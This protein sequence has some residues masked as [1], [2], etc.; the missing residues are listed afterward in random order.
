M[1]RG[2]LAL[3]VLV[4]ACGSPQEAGDT[5][6]TEAEEST[7]TSSP[8]TSSEATTT[9]AAP[10]TTTEGST[11][12]T[13]ATT[14]TTRVLAGNW[15]DQP[16]IVAD[17]GALG[18]WNGSAWV[19]AE[20]VGALPVVGDEDYQV[21][22]LGQ[23]SLTS[24]GPQTTV[25]EPLLNLGVQ[26]DEPDLLGQWP[27]PY[28]IAISGGWELHPHLFESFSDDGSYAGFAREL[29]AG[30]GLDVDSPMIKQLYRTDL[31]GDGTNEVLVVA[32][33]VSRGLFAEE[34]DYSIIFMQKVMQSEVETAVL[35][36]SVINDPENDFLVSFTLGTV[37]DLNGEGKMEIVVDSAYYEGLGVEVWEYADDDLGPVPRL[38]VG[39]G[40]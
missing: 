18:W 6:S 29:L 23:G 32:E 3:V 36:D 40:A 14:S 28:G 2:M 34:G 5:S 12:T 9:T 16:L 39:C 4:A 13:V 15:A 17:F 33:D 21:S 30:R 25:C 26:L 1:T 20:E 11:T 38:S 37:A 35:G 24:G 8:T 7:T 31:E 27:G 10:T 19:R 22:L